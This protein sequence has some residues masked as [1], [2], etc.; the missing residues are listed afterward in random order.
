M[1]FSKHQQQGHKTLFKHLAKPLELVDKYLFGNK[2][3]IFIKRVGRS[4]IL[5]AMVPM[6]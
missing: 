6:L 4:T 2:K 3:T 5:Q 1:N